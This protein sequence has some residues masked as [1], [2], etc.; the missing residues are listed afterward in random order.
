MKYHYYRNISNEMTTYFS[1]YSAI[2]VK[3]KNFNLK[4][5]FMLILPLLAGICPIQTIFTHYFSKIKLKKIFTRR[6]I[7]HNI[8]RK[9][10][11]FRKH[12]GKIFHPETRN[13]SKHSMEVVFQS[14][15]LSILIIE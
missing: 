12:T 11:F 9:K 10:L 3:H 6:R 7:Y 4:Q 8:R 13:N 14:F 2:L 15:G 1:P 5:N